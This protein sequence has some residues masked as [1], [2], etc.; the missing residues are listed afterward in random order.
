MDR[1]AYSA[2]TYFLISTHL[3]CNY[4]RVDL[5]NI[6]AHKRSLRDIIQGSHPPVENRVASVE[7]FQPVN[8]A[9]LDYSVGAALTASTTGVALI[10]A[11][12]I[13]IVTIQYKPQHTLDT[14]TK[15]QIRAPTHT[16]PYPLVQS[17]ISIQTISRSAAPQQTHTH[18]LGSIST[19]FTLEDTINRRTYNRP[20][21][22]KMP[23]PTYST[24]EGRALL[25]KYK[26]SY[27]LPKMV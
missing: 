24:T 19:V 7:H 4:F 25:T 10:Y 26:I 14:S 3:I 2:I 8:Y 21:P 11:V 27:V 6:G 1:N 13:V 15:H 12:K 18:C 17:T 23:S 9:I 16:N 22:S 20:F 5:A